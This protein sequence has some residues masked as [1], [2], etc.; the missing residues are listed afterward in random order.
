MEMRDARDVE[1]LDRSNFCAETAYALLVR[2]YRLDQRDFE[3]ALGSAKPREARFAHFARLLDLSRPGATVDEDELKTAQKRF[4]DDTVQ[5]HVPEVCFVAAVLKLQESAGHFCAGDLFEHAKVAG[6]A[7][8]WMYEYVCLRHLSEVRVIREF[9]SLLDPRSRHLALAEFLIARK[10]DGLNAEIFLPQFC[11]EALLPMV[12]VPSEDA[13][14][15]SREWYFKAL[16][17]DFA[18]IES[19]VP[20]EIRAQFDRQRGS[21]ISRLEERLRNSC[22]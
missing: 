8:E 18:L 17:S 13:Q 12:E 15:L 7:H 16:S 19:L 22:F 11:D 21:R 4:W 5:L 10:W 1:L 9:A 20:L 3:L 2:R 14:R 6:E